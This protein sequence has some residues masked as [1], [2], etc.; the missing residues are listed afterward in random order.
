MAHD[1]WERIQQV[2][3]EAVERPAR[4]RSAFVE[5]ACGGDDALREEVASLLAAHE[6]A[7]PDR[8][9]PLGAEAPG[10]LDPAGPKGPDPYL[11]KT[12]DGFHLVELIGR[13]GMGR[14]Y[15]ATEREPVRDVALKILPAALM[16]RDRL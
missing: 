8:L 9:A 16:T 6:N 12:I 3:Q 10:D 5:R 14:V 15:R 2:F 1:R 7:P 4:E 13:G 11:G